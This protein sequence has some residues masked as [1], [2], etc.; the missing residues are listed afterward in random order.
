MSETRELH[1][2][3]E[4]MLAA[5]LTEHF[6]S[7]VMD[8]A[9]EAE[10]ADLIRAWAATE[11]T[12]ARRSI[13]TDLEEMIMEGDETYHPSDLDDVICEAIARIPDGQQR[14]DNQV[15]RRAMGRKLRDAREA[16][17]FS[18][19]RQLAKHLNL[20]PTTIRRIEEGGNVQW[21]TAVTYMM[22][23]GLRP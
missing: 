23:A 7:W 1:D 20:S 11:D 10:Y 16:S 2:I 18:S 22:W 17:D 5:G 6:V 21:Q 8:Y 12:R 4:Q 14:V 15:W 19:V 3:A 13:E 9:E